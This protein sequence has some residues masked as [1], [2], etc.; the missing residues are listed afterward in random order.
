MNLTTDFECPK[1]S[2]SCNVTAIEEVCGLETFCNDDPCAHVD[3]P[4]YPG[5]GDRLEAARDNFTCDCHP[6]CEGVEGAPSV[7]DNI[8]GA[9]GDNNTVFNT[10]ASANF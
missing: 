3:I 6:P 2:H 5:F 1:C 9:G 8:L 10:F 7:E 4:F